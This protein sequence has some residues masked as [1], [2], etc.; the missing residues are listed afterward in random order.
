MVSRLKGIETFEYSRVTPMSH[1][2]SL[3]MPSRLKGIETLLNCPLQILSIFALDMV[4]RLKG[5]ETIV[6]WNTKD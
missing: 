6:P 2:S 3:D 4:S 1:S 5:I